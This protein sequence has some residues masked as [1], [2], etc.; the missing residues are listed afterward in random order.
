[1]ESQTKIIPVELASGKVL[2]IEST[3]FEVD[4]DQKNLVLGEEI[5]SNVSLNIR[6]LKD[7]TD[8]IEEIA[9]TIKASLDKV[10]PTKACVEFGVEFGYES[11]QLTAMIVKGT[12]KANLKITLEWSH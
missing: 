3:H 5:E 12:G 6:P 8:A 2:R 1:M 9:E 4:T 10:K 11:G 7:V